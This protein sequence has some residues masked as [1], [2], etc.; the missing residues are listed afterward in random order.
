MATKVRRGPAGIA[1]G[2]QPATGPISLARSSPRSGSV[3]LRGSRA[4]P[5][6]RHRI[7]FGWYG[8]KFS[9]LNWLLPLLPACHHYIEPFGGSAAVL[10]NRPPAPLE[11]YN[12]LDGEVANFFRVLRTRRDELIESIGLTPFS[13]EEFLEAL[14]P[15]DAQL[16][17]LERA[18]RF[19]VRA[20]QARTGLAQ[21][22]TAGRWANCRTTSRSGMAGAVS[23]WLGSV[24]A[25]PEIAERMLRVQIEHRPALEV[26]RRYDS[27]GSLF[28]C[29]PPYLASTRGDPKSYGHEMSESDHVEL[30]AVLT[31]CRGK[32]AVSGYDCELM[33]RLYRGWRRI[34]GPEKT[35]HSAKTPRQETLWTNFA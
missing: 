24:E 34:Q 18:R 12:D 2:A 28:Y 17:E 32:V 35:A 11:T 30:A 8:G 23:R 20:R 13:R 31:H 22:A 9:H 7:A 3:L 4:S 15:P 21:T 6:E 10:L 19:F 25:L 33:R 26:I 29:D 1:S 27:D 16:S 14:G 5:P